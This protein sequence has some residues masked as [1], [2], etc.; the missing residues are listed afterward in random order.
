VL[1]PLD[2]FAT[3]VERVFADGGRGLNVTL[4]FKLEAH[5]ACGDRL[6]ERARRAGAV[7]WL[8]FDRE[9]LAGDNTDGV[10]LVCDLERLLH[11]SRRSLKDAR[12]L[13]VGAGGAARGVIGPLLAC[14]PAAL[15]IVNRDAAKAVALA[16]AFGKEGP[17]LAT[18][19]DAIDD[20]PFDVIVNATSASIV[21]QSL[22]IAPSILARAGLVYDMMYGAARTRFLVDAQRAGAAAIADGLG[23][24]VEQAAESFF[25][26]HG[27]RPET[28]T[29]RDHLRAR[30]AADATR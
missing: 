26:W 3:T 23:M 25:L 10:G 14:E 6:S 4:P 8:A 1:A 24:L 29:V 19:F 2:G 12:L 20:A 5:A 16:T 27:V 9:G 28:A 13:L 15:I 7:N 17:V 18:T 11:P 21:D 22:P 30:L